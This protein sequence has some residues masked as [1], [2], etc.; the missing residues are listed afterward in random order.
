MARV[1]PT[2]SIESRLQLGLGLS[3]ALLIAGAWW[4]GHE[5]LHHTA[6][7]YVL[8]RLQH[9]AEALM[10]SL[11]VTA[12]G[13]VHLGG[14][15]IAPVY[16]Q[17]YSGHYHLVLL[18]GAEV[19]R[20]RS[21]WDQGLDAR[22]LTPGQST[23]WRAF[24][25]RG[26]EL[27]VWGGGFERDGRR[28]TLVV[29]EDLLPLQGPLRSFER[30]FALRA[31][32]G[33]GA[34]LLV[35][36]LVV[37]RAFT[38]LQP[39]YR[40][41]E[42]LERG[43]AIALTEA[44][45]AEILP[46]V[47]KINRLLDIYAKRLERSRNA[48]G[49]LA[50]ALKGPLSLMVRELDTGPK[51]LDPSLRVLLSDQLERVRG[52]LDRELKR[53]RLAGD[54]VPGPGFDP[55]T[56]LPVLQRLLQGMYPGKALQLEVRMDRE[57]ALPADREDMLELAGTLLDNACKWCLA[58]VLCRLESTPQGAR[59]CVED[60]GPGCSESELQTIAG[61]GARLDEGVQGYG[62]GLS[63]AREIVDLYGG[64]LE[65]GRSPTLG[66]FRA[67]ALLPL[68]RRPA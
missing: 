12:G 43:S 26:Q 67:E 6:E 14:R 10:G 56:E 21:L 37:R 45:P 34:M 60:D 25:P 18:N 48:A 19:L 3:L 54:G 47:T 2:G 49:N 29:A 9:D 32:L 58:R 23:Q 17:P 41:I 33:L 61:R 44:V 16:E 27:L 1:S 22:P 66:G 50:H 63:I 31:I 51:S 57:G 68:K 11:Q 5:A 38:R 8:S 24:G 13:G 59:L 30:R 4:L 46:L 7:A 36:R 52:L 65:L 15:G 40:D 35:Q 42:A 53:A 55:L 39:V 64:R 62:L 28:L 20:S